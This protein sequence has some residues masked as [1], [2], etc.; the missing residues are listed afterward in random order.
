[1]YTDFSTGNNLKQSFNSS[2]DTIERLSVP[3]GSSMFKEGATPL[4]I[5]QFPKLKTFE[6]LEYDCYWHLVS[7]GNQYSGIDKFLRVH[8]KTLQDLTAI[9]HPSF[10]FSVA[11]EPVEDLS[12]PLRYNSFKGPL[13][14]L[15]LVRGLFF[16]DTLSLLEVTC[17]FQVG[18]YIMKQL[19]DF[20]KKNITGCLKRLQDLKLNIHPGMDYDWK[21]VKAGKVIRMLDL[22]AVI[23]GGSL[24]SWSRSLPP[25]QLEVAVLGE[26]LKRFTKLKTFHLCEEVIGTNISVDEYILELASY[27]PSLEVVNIEE[28]E[29]FE[30]AI[31]ALS[32]RISRKSDVPERAF[33]SS[34][35]HVRI[36][37][38]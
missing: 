26:A 13:L 2:A 28:E 25:I 31:H 23:C 30:D 22:W 8:R 15:E 6:V 4:W 9:S 29:I 33:I 37:V 11:F 7:D 18:K 34:R 35:C 16:S 14:H 5:M 20:L 32:I 38:S 19:F 27:C 36:P 1:V 17:S 12:E 21:G 10:R 24:T 3:F